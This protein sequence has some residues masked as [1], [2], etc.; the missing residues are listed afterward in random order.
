[1]GAR[2]CC[3][4]WRL[5]EEMLCVRQWSGEKKGGGAK[6]DGVWKGEGTKGREIGVV[7][8]WRMLIIHSF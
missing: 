2:C 1:M 4:G 6:G 5:R 3:C 8:A 7:F